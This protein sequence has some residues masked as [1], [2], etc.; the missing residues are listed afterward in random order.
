MEDMNE[1][2]HEISIALIQKDIQY[3]RESMAKIDLAISVF[4]RNF[5]RKE[6]AVNL[7]KQAEDVHK[8]I[9]QQLESK[10]DKSEFE[11]IRSTLAKINWVIISA[12]VVAVL[13][14][15]VN[16]GVK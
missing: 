11:P 9:L 6:E 16:V 7:Q 13:A 2:T 5:M 10:L 3:I 15:V 4:D 14:L 1:N 12:L 8:K